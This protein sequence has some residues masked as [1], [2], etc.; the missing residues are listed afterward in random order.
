MQLSF[1]IQYRH[2]H[3]IGKTCVWLTKK[4]ATVL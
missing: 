3:I 4:Y 2:A 1:I